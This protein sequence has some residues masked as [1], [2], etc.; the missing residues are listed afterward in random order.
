MRSAG[1]DEI[2]RLKEQAKALIGE[3]DAEIER[4]NREIDEAE[5]ILEAG[6]FAGEQADEDMNGDIAR[7]ENELLQFNFRSQAELQA[8][9]ENHDAEIADLQAKHEKE[10]ERLKKELKWT[11]ENQDDIQ[12][13]DS[14]ASQ[15]RTDAKSESSFG[16]GKPTEVREVVVARSRLQEAEKEVEALEAELRRVTTQ[17]QHQIAEQARNAKENA[18]RRQRERVE[19]KQ[20]KEELMARRKQD[21]YKEQIEELKQEMRNEKQAAEEKLRKLIERNSDLDREFAAAL[22]DNEEKTEMLTRVRTRSRPRT[23]KRADNSSF[24]AHFSVVEAD[25][26]RLRDENAELRH[27]LKGLDKLAYPTQRR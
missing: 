4:L 6:R 3:K 20:H 23:A 2:S 18:E 14:R 16:N 13:C 5:R 10:I 9:Q 17:Q 22:A 1:R 27:I 21:E 7:V 8:M 12:K 19:K 24:F 15:L 26:I 25:I 11:R